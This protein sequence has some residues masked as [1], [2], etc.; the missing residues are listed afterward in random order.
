MG[1]RISRGS[2]RPRVNLSTFGHTECFS[3]FPRKRAFSLFSIAPP[4]SI[5]MRFFSQKKKK[6]KTQICPH[7]R[8]KFV[9]KIKGN[10]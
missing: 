7:Q 10:I 2:M 8:L 1:A 6:E 9:K 5:M 3:P 4:F